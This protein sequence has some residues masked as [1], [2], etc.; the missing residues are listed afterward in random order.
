[1]RF[2]LEATP[3]ELWQK[4]TALIEELVKA[5][6]QTNPD[7]SE[8]LEKALPPKEQNLKYP[9]LR[10]L[11]A[12]TS[13]EY[14]AMTKR[15]LAD[16]G[17]V[18]DQS[19]K[20]PGGVLAKAFGEQEEKDPGAEEEEKLEPGDVD[21]ETGDLIP[22]EEEEEEEG[23]GEEGE[24]KSLEKALTA[25]EVQKIAKGYADKIRAAA[26]KVKAEL[27]Q[28]DPLDHDFTKPIADKDSIAYARVKRV[29]MGR[30]YTEG[31]FEEGGT[32]YGY[33]VNQLI[34]FVREARKAS[35]NGST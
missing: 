26:R 18:L 7:L 29:L 5:F 31:D 20:A 2:H 10:G 13:K 6:A 16:I 21:P 17:K 12:V 22:E 19:V 15:M 33:S 25:E 28:S 8:V 27:P 23:E 11:K 14:D 4:G 32:L 9:T 1:M 35:Q 34:D 24:E 3:A 30:G